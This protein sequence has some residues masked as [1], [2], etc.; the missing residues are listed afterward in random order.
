MQTASANN[1][2]VCRVVVFPKNQGKTRSESRNQIVANQIASLVL[3]SGLL[4]LGRCNGYAAHSLF[5]S[6]RISMSEV[7]A[8]AISWAKPG[9]EAQLAEALEG[10]LEPTHKEAGM[11]QYEMHRDVREPR[12]FVFIERWEDEK[13]FDAH[14]NSSH[15]TAYLE[16]VADWVEKNTIHVLRKVR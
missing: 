11:L 5:R 13:T 14:C 6:R 16:K 9:Y 12:C 2:A 8:V 7:S 4:F 15:V 1:D 10:L 3:R